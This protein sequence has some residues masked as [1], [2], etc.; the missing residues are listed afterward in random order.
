MNAVEYRLGAAVALLWVACLPL[1][2][3]GYG[4]AFAGRMLSDRL[5]KERQRRR[6]EKQRETR[7]NAY[8]TKA[9]TRNLNFEISSAREAEMREETAGLWER[10]HGSTEGMVKFGMLLLEVEEAVDSS[11]IRG[12]DTFGNPVLLGRRSGLKGWLAEHCPHIG[13]KT[14]MRYKT[15]V[16]KMLENDSLPSYR[17]TL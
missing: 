15:L 5:Q 11:C 16:R 9:R 12:I 7:K 14:A 4:I 13:Y 10:A 8:A 3:V 1:I 2:G 17:P 6:C